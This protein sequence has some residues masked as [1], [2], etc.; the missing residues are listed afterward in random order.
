MRIGLIENNKYYLRIIYNNFKMPRIS[1]PKTPKT[2]SKVEVESKSEPKSKVEVESKSEPKFHEVDKI[3]RKKGRPKKTPKSET[4]EAANPPELV[5]PPE[6]VNPRSENPRSENP[7]VDV[8]KKRRPNKIVVDPISDEE[9]EIVINLSKARKQKK[10][11]KR[12][13]K[14]SGE[15]EEKRLTKKRGRPKKVAKDSE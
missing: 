8:P 9:V 1:K 10:D 3:H 7:P 4:L 12:K 15:L 11:V 6:V 14:E 5:N 13:E 2:D